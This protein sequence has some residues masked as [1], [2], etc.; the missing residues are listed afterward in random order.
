[1]KTSLFPD[2]RPFMHLWT[3]G[4]MDQSDLSVRRQQMVTV[5]W[6]RTL[7]LAAQV[8]LLAVV[9]LLLHVSLPWPVLTVILGALVLLNVITFIRLRQGHS[10]GS[11]EVAAQLF[12]DLAAFTFVLYFTGGVTN[13]FVSLYLPL[14]GLAAALLPWAQVAVLALFSVVAYTVLMGNYIPLVLANPDDGVHFHLVGMWLNFLVSVLILVGFV[15]RL[16]SSIRNR[17]QALGRAQQRLAS[18]SRLAALGNQAASIAHQLGTPV[19]TIA[20]IVSDWKNDPAM[21]AQVREM[22]VLSAQVQSITDTLGQLRDQIEVNPRHNADAQMIKPSEWL[23][24]TLGIWRTRNPQHEVRLMP[25]IASIAGEFKVRKELLELGLITLLDN[26]AQSQQRASVRD[27]LQV[28][29]QCDHESLTL[30]V[31]D[32]GGGI[33][34]ELLPKIGQQ[35]FQANGQGMG[36]FLLANLLEREGGKLSLRNLNPGVCASLSLPVLSQ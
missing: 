29:M 30:F 2:H 19:S 11:F 9:G 36:L 31:N 6:M 21:H 12:A 35:L 4:L 5:M 1:M 18:E 15:A 27:P 3:E 14:L 17:D 20:T 7:A 25:S 28:G 33:D 13:P 8:V 16:S 10:V 34:A 26:A 22:N 32:A 24:N 23:Q